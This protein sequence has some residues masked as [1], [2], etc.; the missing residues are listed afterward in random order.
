MAWRDFLTS[1][2]VLPVAYIFRCH[3]RRISSPAISRHF[4]GI[5]IDILATGIAAVMAFKLTR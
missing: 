2:L 1:A 4:A 3:E 5:V